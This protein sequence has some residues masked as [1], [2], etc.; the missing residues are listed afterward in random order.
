MG[1]A[2]MFTNRRTV[3]PASWLVPWDLVTAVT[4]FT[5]T[6][7]GHPVAGGPTGTAAEPV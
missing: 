2:F 6:V 3:A 4:G 1:A 5:A 7:T